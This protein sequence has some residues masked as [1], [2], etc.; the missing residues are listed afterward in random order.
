MFSEFSIITFIIGEKKKVQR[1]RSFQKT[2]A[3]L[4]EV[5]IFNFSSV[6]I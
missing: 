3:D 2:L 4:F 6:S 1:K 5:L